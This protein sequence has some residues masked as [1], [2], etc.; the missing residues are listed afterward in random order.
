MTTP[1]SAPYGHRIAAGLLRELLV[2]YQITQALYVAARL[3]LADHL[4]QPTTIDALAKATGADHEALHF[5]V[6][7]LVGYGVLE[8][9][10]DL[11]VTTEVGRL[12][13]KDRSDSLRPT[14]IATGKERYQSWGSLLQTVRSGRPV[15]SA[16]NG[17]ALHDFYAEH[18]G[19]A[20]PFNGAMAALTNSMVDQLIESYDFSRHSLVVEIGGGLGV[21]MAEI[22]HRYP[23]L[24]GSILD[25]PHVVADAAQALPPRILADRLTLISGDA[26][27]SVPE[28]ADL[29]L[30]KMVLCDFPDDDALKIL[31][32]V[33]KAIS[34]EGTLVIFDKIRPEVHDD[35]VSRRTV[36]SALNLLVMTGGRER[37]EEE[38]R[39]LLTR[40][41]FDLIDVMRT[42]A[43]DGEIYRVVAM[44]GKVAPL[45]SG[46]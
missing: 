29:Y 44:P 2:G 3:H 45:S 15:F 40:A 11:Y 33:R 31:R 43:L 4:I 12:L 35:E 10:G 21:F 26:R 5:L 41:G 22:L 36:M 24:R 19:A 25:L 7:A 32:S 1:H 37:S 42:E 18:P 38:Y 20:A 34:D 13:E 28:N 16:Q 8:R 6:R 46:E 9:S 39:L 27:Q 14:V 23:S 17:V 30:T